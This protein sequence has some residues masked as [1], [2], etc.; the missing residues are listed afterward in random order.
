[1]KKI[2]MI[3]TVTA[4]CIAGVGCAK[5]Q[6]EAGKNASTG[7]LQSQK[8]EKGQEI[9]VITTSKG[10][11]YMMFYPE[12]A[13]K[14]VENFKTL[15]KQGYYD[16]LT[17]HRVIQDFM[18]QTGDPTGTG[19]GGESVW[20]EPFEDEISPKL[21]FFN[22]A[23][24]MANSGPNTNGSQFFIVQSS[25]VQKEPMDMLKEAKESKDD[26]GI[27]IGEDNFVSLKDIFTDEVIAYY[28]E[29]GGA[30][31]LEYAFGAPYTIFAQVYDGFD[32]IDTIAA[33]ETDEKDKPVEDVIIESIKF[34]P[35][36]G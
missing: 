21:H 24:A 35:Y 8:P 18:I 31:G 15:A 29:H 19:A 36:E 17:F 33:V 34:Q 23:V 28:E 9:A 7:V 13:P 4:L 11:L 5:A 6:A 16:G 20:G 14:A 2:W 32:T 1:M 12:E 25:E 27:K 10:E 22:G 3:L 26:L 30:V